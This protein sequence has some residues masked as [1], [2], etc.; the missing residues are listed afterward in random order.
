MKY[1]LMIYG[2]QAGFAAFSPEDF[3]TLVERHDA[4]ITKLRET[5]ELL[6]AQ[7]LE[8]E[9]QAKSVRVRDGVPVVTD[10]PFVE[11]K[12]FL[13]SLYIVECTAERA[14][15][16]AAMLPEA[17]FSAVEIRPVFEGP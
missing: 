6:Q 1:A 15:E 16:L 13:A 4:W 12:E 2:N 7:G 17:E 14:V 11:A 3:K 9:E 10:G 5:G 8:G